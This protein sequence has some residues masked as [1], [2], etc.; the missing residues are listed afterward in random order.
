LH[1]KLIIIDNA[2]EN[3]LLCRCIPQSNCVAEKLVV[4][5]VVVVAVVV[6]I[7]LNHGLCLYK[8]SEANKNYIQ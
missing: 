2:G 4:V 8:G 7:A 1:L 3:L 6:V 5:V